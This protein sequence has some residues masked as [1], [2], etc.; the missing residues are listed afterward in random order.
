MAK[1]YS[2]LVLPQNLALKPTSDRVK[3]M[4]PGPPL[5][6]NE[7]VQRVGGGIGIAFPTD[8]RQDIPLGCRVFGAFSRAITKEGIRR[9]PVGRKYCR[10]RNGIP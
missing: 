5:V 8:D 10:K 1:P 2:R 4:V 7:T 9:F 6:K 3:E